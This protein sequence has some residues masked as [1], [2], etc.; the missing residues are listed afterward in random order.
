[1]RRGDLYRVYK[2]S[3]RDPKRHRVFVVVSR[4]VV[5]ESRHT[6]VICAPIYTSGSGLSTEV[7]VGPDEGLKHPSSIHCD[8]LVSILK[9]RLTDY[10]GALRPTQLSQLD[11]ALAIAVGIG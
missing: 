2:G 3:G 11:A 6:T 10:V 5:I 7:P 4:Q 1:M 8:E 9:S